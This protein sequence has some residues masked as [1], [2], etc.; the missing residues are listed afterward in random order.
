MTTILP[1]PYSL[2]PT[3]NL[4]AKTMSGLEEIL[5]QELRDLGASEIRVLQRAVSFNG[6]KQLM[7][8]ANLWCRTAL[9]ILKPI[10]TF[11]VKN[12]DDLYKQVFDIK[13][14]DYIDLQNT[15]AIDTVITDSPFTNSLYISQKTKDAIVDRFYFY[16]SKRPSVDIRNPDLRINLHINNLDCTLS[17]DSSG[18]SLHK[19][20]YRQKAGLAPI[21][22]VLAAGLIM[23]SGWKMDCDF[24]DPMCGSGTFLIEAAMIANNI[25]TAFYR[26]EFGFQKWKDYDSVL[27]N[28]LLEDSLKEQK[29]FEFKILGFDISDDAVSNAEE[30]IR[31]ARLHKDIA[32]HCSAFAD[33]D[34]QRLISSGQI[35]AHNSQLPTPDSGRPTPNYGLIIMNPPYGERLKEED[36]I[37]LYKSIG[38]TLKNKCSGFTAW[39]ISSDLEAIKFIGL[40]PSR[41]IKIYNG[42]LECRFLKFEVYEGSKKFS[43]SMKN[44]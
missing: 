25:P 16:Q 2:F 10:N 7:Y 20:G 41:K 30:N 40:K 19:R 6:D 23:L 38:D 34:K 1:T 32:I 21:N 4:L 14:E 12:E 37:G 15:F 44:E 8:K 39:I 22:E 35:T 17:L 11:T 29:E 27:W 5:A 13:W 36:I 43:K 42:P 28:Q 9:R 3:Q 31:F 26:K 33:F 24:I 18:V